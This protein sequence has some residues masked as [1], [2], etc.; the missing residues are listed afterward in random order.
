ME[1]RRLVRVTFSRRVGRNKITYLFQKMRFAPLGFLAIL[2]GTKVGEADHD[3]DYMV[4]DMA[5]EPDKTSGS[6]TMYPWSA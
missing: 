1:S 6:G 2:R 5:P 3:H 4:P